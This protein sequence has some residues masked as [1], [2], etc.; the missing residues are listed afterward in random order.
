MLGIWTIFTSGYS[1]EI[2][3][4]LLVAWLIA[5]VFSITAHEY[6]HALTAYKMG[7][8]TAKMAGRMSLNPA[9]H[10]DPIGAICLVLF[11]FGWAKGVPI[12]PNLFRNYRKGQVLVS[13]SGI[14]TNLVLGIIFTFL[15]VVVHLFLDDSVYFWFFV[16]ELFQ[17]LAVIN[18]VLAVFNILPIYPLDGFSFLEAFLR[19]DNKFLVFMRKYGMIILLILLLMGIISLLMN[20]V[21]YVFYGLLG[22]LF[23]RIFVWH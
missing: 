21:I 1:I 10:L 23:E 5:I 12:N 15:S 2:I 19:Y 18:Y 4:A 8:P 6:A 11:G 16:Q 3:F 9:K 7:D 17:Y 22:G 14:L 13:L 20:F